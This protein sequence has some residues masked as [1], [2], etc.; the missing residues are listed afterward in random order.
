MDA[1]NCTSDLWESK[2]Q[3]LLDIEPALYS[4][5]LILFEREEFFLV[6]R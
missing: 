6:E 3:T 5:V 2:Q 4:Q 1:G